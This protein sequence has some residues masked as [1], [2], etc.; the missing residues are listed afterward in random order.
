MNCG[1]GCG[2]RRTYHWSDE[3]KRL[4]ADQ[5][6]RIEQAGNHRGSHREQ[7]LSKLAQI[8]GNPRDACLRF[9]RRHGVAEKRSYREW[10]TREQQRL[11]ELIDDVPVEEAARVLR[12]PPAS[13][14]SMLHRLG[15]GVRQSREWFTVSL[16][17]EALHISRAEV[18]KWIDR[19]WLQCRIVQARS[20]RVQIIDVEDFC[21]FVKVYGRQ[22]IGN[23]LSYEGLAFVRDY[24]FP[25]SHAD[26][27]SVRGPYNKA[28]KQREA[29]P[30]MNDPDD[31]Q[32]NVT[33]Q[34]A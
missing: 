28:P 14:R 7:I 21:S 6:Q 27:L 8:S 23:R 19:S 24:V 32:G 1:N 10:T 34:S 33:E 31:V 25:R 26:L 20:V 16:L 4:V 30:I 9:L 11:V 15:L 29:N 18:R 3:A 2:A 12:R 13:V 5:R 22:V 17:A